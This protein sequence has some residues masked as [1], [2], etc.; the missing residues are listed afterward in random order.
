VR[1]RAAEAAG[2]RAGPTKGLATADVTNE[3]AALRCAE[4]AELLERL[5]MEPAGLSARTLREQVKACAARGAGTAD[6]RLLDAEDRARQQRA[7][8]AQGSLAAAAR[9]PTL[10]NDVCGR[11]LPA[12]DKRRWS[13]GVAALAELQARQAAAPYHA[14]ITPLIRRA[15]WCIKRELQARQGL[16]PARLLEELGRQLAR[17]AKAKACEDCRARR[18]SYALPVSL[19]RFSSV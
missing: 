19:E 12:A 10:H 3:T 7:H 16:D 11:A 6:M 15:V 5:H 13:D 14:L 18:P 1:L 17:V 2:G 4:G 8:V 9:A